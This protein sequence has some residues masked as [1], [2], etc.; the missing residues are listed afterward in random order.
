MSTEGKAAALLLMQS[1]DSA[2]DILLF[3]RK[4][5]HFTIAGKEN[6]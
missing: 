2:E 4:A 6:N 1:S 3:Y 5:E